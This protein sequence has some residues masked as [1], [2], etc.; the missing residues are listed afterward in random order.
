MFCSQ[1]LARKSLLKLP[2]LGKD[3]APVACQV[4]LEPAIGQFREFEPHRV[5]SSCAQID[6]RKARERGLATLD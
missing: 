1:T 3:V 6:F 4:I 5:L 2:V